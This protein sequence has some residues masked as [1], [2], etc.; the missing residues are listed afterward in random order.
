MNLVRR[1]D[2]AWAWGEGALT[3]AVLLA[4][5]LMAGFQ[6]GVR[7]LAYYDIA[8][9]SALLTDME[10]ADSFLRKATLWLA[11]LGASLA[12]HGDKHIGIDILSRIAPPKPRWIMRAIVN[13]LGGVVTLGLT[14]AFFS[15][16]KLNLTERPMEYEVLGNEGSMHVCDASFELLAQLEFDAPSAFCALRALYNAVGVPAETPGAAFQVIVPVAFF[17]MSLRM[18]GRGAG[19]LAVLAGGPDAIVTADKEIALRSSGT[20][21][22][23]PPAGGVPSSVSSV[24]PAPA[25]P[26]ELGEDAGRGQPPS[27]GP[28]PDKPETRA[29][30]DDRKDEE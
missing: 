6:A 12:S 8:W 24:P 14:Y 13:L 28:A 18:L 9:A 20:S 29:K 30:A 11:F 21:L 19:A 10:W 5:V 27:D 3:V 1:L 7:N 26:K 16:V 22:A 4:M 15:A 23:P 25:V 17:V 2:R